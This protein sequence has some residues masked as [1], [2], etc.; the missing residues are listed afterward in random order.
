MTQL[1]PVSNPNRWETTLLSVP[2][3]VTNI[4]WSNDGG[5]TWTPATYVSG[6]VVCDATAQTR[7]TVSDMEII[8]PYG[9]DGISPFRTRMHIQHGL[10]YGNNTF[11]MI[12]MGMYR[13]TDVSRNKSN[14][15]LLTVS[16][17]SFEHYLQSPWGSFTTTQQYDAQSAQGLLESLIQEVL[18]DAL[19]SYQNVDPSQIIPA[20]TTDGDRWQLIDGSTSDQSIA[21]AL[22]CRIYPDGNG[23]WIVAPRGTIEDAPTWSALGGV[24]LV[25]STE[26]VSLDGLYN[27]IAVSGTDPILGTAIGPYSVA[28]TDPYSRTNINVPINEGGIGQS[29][30]QYQSDLITTQAQAVAAGQSLL[31]DSRG[32]QQTV[33]MENV[34]NPRFRPDCAGTVDTGSGVQKAIFDALEFDL[35]GAPFSNVTLRTTSTQFTGILTEFVDPSLAGGN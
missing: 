11:D 29:V 26:T 1:A 25:D 2:Q 33:A 18:P 32:L 35:T 9:Y 13:I 30:Y 5:A 28:D 8:A 4:T 15:N 16:G 22:G 3:W 21:R 23:I 10:Q 12:G 17:S 24:S 31:M 20:I 14:P 6:T 19:I 7:W 27:V 34:Y